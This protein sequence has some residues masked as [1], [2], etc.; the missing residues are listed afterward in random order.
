MKCS[1]FTAQKA[2]CS[3]FLQTGLKCSNLSVGIS[4][5]DN[6]AQ[7]KLAKKPPIEGASQGIR[8]FPIAQG[9]ATH[10]WVW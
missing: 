1:C 4:I 10:L 7:H 5:S 2:I 6:T 9:A 3:N 8:V